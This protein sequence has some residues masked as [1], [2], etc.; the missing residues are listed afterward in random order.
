VTA[1]GGDDLLWLCAPD[2]DT[3]GA[4]TS[5]TLPGSYNAAE[6]AENGFAV[7]VG[8]Y[9]NNVSAGATGSVSGAIV[10]SNQAGWGCW[11][12]RIPEAAAGGGTI[13]K[14][15]GLLMRGCG[16]ADPRPASW[17][18]PLAPLRGFGPGRNLRENTALQELQPH[19]RQHHVQRRKRRR[20]LSL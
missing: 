5:T 4:Y 7:L 19:G 3:S 8:C 6:D 20:Y 13:T 15:L 17:F 12:V 1:V 10:H 2:V 9:R 16:Y 14:P 18:L 11:L